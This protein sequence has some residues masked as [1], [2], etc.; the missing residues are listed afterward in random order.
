MYVYPCFILKPTE[1]LKKKLESLVGID[2]LF[3]N[4]ESITGERAAKK[5]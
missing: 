2:I 3:R 5:C 1:I 4:T